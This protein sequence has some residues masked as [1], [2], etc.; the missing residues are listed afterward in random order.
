MLKLGA[1]SFFK[2]VGRYRELHL[3]SVSGYH[4]ADTALLDMYS[5]PRCYPLVHTLRC[6]AGGR[7]GELPTPT[8][9]GVC[10]HLRG[11]ESPNLF[12]M[13][14]FVIAPTL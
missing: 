1:Q 12:N 8:K 6:E 5:C 7:S 13:R 14:S 9:L 3:C 4:R 10:V 11:F 2:C